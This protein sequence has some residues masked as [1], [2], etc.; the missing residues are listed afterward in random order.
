[1]A[2]HPQCECPQTE[3]QTLDQRLAAVEAAFRRM[4]Q[5]AQEFQRKMQKIERD[6]QENADVLQSYQAEMT[7]W[8]GMLGAVLH[9][10]AEAR[11]RKGGEGGEWKG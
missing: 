4:E 10:E 8:F 6:L 11:A 9:D 7:A 5:E 2:S 3:L 1:M